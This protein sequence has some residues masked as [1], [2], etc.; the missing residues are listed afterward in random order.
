MILRVLLGQ[1]GSLDPSSDVQEK[2]CESMAPGWWERKTC[3]SG[4]ETIETQI[5][6]M[7]FCFKSKAPLGVKKSGQVDKKL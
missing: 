2:G 6:E 4:C 3:P 7:A 1:P 5:R